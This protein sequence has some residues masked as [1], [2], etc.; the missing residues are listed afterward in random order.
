MERMDVAVVG[1]QPALH[2]CSRARQGL[3]RDAATEEG[4][5]VANCD[6]ATQRV[7]GRGKRNAVAVH[8]AVW[9]FLRGVSMKLPCHISKRASKMEAGRHLEARFL[10]L[11]AV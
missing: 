8:A 4:A 7:L 11:L 9:E 6:T 2:A 3:G 10:R 5:A 1:G